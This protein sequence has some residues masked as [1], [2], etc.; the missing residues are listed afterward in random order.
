[1]RS[2][3]FPYHLSLG[4]SVSRAGPSVIITGKVWHESTNE[5][6]GT[7]VE[8]ISYDYQDLVEVLKMLRQIF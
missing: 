8:E 6:G 3:E 1:V 4:I 5:N 2:T 7:E